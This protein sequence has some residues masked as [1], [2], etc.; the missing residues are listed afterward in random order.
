MQVHSADR[1]DRQINKSCNRTDRR[2]EN[3]GRETRSRQRCCQ[4]AAAVIDVSNKL[5]IIVGCN[6]LFMLIVDEVAILLA[7]RNPQYQG[8]SEGGRNHRCIAC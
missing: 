8:L 3:S 4:V 6:L 7:A 1:Y 5:L 2:I